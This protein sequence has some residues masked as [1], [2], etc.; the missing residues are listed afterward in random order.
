MQIDLA[1]LEFL[2]ILSGWN[3]SSL[4][5]FLSFLRVLSLRASF[6]YCFKEVMKREGSFINCLAVF[7]S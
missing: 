7:Q 5:N 4:V 1:A 3:L 2:A 6:L